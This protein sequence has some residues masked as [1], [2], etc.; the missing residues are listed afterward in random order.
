MD[1]GEPDQAVTRD[2][3]ERSEWAARLSREEQLKEK[4]KRD[5]ERAKRKKEREDREK[6][7]TPAQHR[8]RVRDKLNDIHA[9]ENVKHKAMDDMLAKIDMHLAT[10]KTQTPVGDASSDVNTKDPGEYF[11]ASTPAP[12]I[13]RRRASKKPQIF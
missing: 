11:N 9:A 5:A 7:R 6:E 13:G 12:S 2:L 1:R 8:D 4:E 3:I 10:P